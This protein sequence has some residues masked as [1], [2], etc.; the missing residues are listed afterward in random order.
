MRELLLWGRRRRAHATTDGFRGCDWGSSSPRSRAPPAS[1]GRSAEHHRRP[2]AARNPAPSG[3]GRDERATRT[4]RS[5]H[6]SRVTLA[7]PR[8]RI[9]LVLPADEPI[10]LLLP[11]VVGLVGHRRWMTPAVTRSAPS[12]AP[13]S[14]RSQPAGGRRP[15]GA[16]LRVDSIV[17]AP[18]AAIVHDVSDEV[19]DDLARRRGRWGTPRPAVDR[20]G[21][22]ACRG[23]RRGPSRRS[24]ARALAVGLIGVAVVIAGVGPR[25]F[26]SRDLSVAVAA[27]RCRDGDEHRL[28]AWTDRSAVRCTLWTIG[29]GGTVLASAR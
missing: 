6:L 3:R 28:P 23:H 20:D 24:R 1:G 19:A 11:E 29:A 25:L 22:L 16:M 2:A 4:G 5:G 7:G 8:R 13:C 14:I 9:D 10:G 21:G 26:G 15:D 17:E 27:R 18:P 12:T